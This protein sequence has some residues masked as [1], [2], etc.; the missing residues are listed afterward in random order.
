MLRV[1]IIALK[2]QASWRGKH[3]NSDDED[4]PVLHYFP[5]TIKNWMNWCLFIYLFLMRRT[6]IYSAGKGGIQVEI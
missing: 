5:K 1:L 6:G 3:T 2:F 4:E